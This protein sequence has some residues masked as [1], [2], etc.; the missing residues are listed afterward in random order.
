MRERESECVCVCVRESEC[1]CVRERERASEREVP[2]VLSA[3]FPVALE[4]FQHPLRQPNHRRT[5]EI[6]RRDQELAREKSAWEPSGSCPPARQNHQ[7]SEWDYIALFR[8]LI[9]TGACRNPPACGTHQ[10]N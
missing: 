4:H 3:D 6:E 8:Y 2:Q 10:G 9:C 1:V 7:P 5:P